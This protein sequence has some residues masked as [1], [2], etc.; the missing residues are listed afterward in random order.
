MARWKH[1]CSIGKNISHAPPDLVFGAAVSDWM[2]GHVEKEEISFFGTQDAFVD[3]AFGQAFSNLLEL[4]ADFHEIPSF[5]FIRRVRVSM[6]Y[7]QCR[8][9][10]P[11][12]RS[13]HELTLIFSLD[14]II[15]NASSRRTSPVS[16]SSMTSMTRS[17]NG[18][19]RL[20]ESFCMLTRPRKANS[21][22]MQPRRAYEMLSFQNERYP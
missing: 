4:V 11:L 21:M 16:V 1:H 13:I 12:M 10:L 19:R 20:D 9:F 7:H 8:G 15:F 5:T 2:G 17:A 6:K 3:E 18:N 14:F 22:T